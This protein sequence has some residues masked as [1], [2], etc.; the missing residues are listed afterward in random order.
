MR[1]AATASKFSNSETSGESAA[2]ELARGSTRE[3]R[4]T[5]ALS[6]SHSISQSPQALFFI[7]R[8]LVGCTVFAHQ[9]GTAQRPAR[10]QGL[11]SE[12]RTFYTDKSSYNNE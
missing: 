3:C 6:G 10:I 11:R 9:H 1:N 12:M 8:Q 2:S 5:D 4:P 7:A